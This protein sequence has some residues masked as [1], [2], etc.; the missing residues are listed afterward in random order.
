MHGRSQKKLPI[1]CSEGEIN[2]SVSVIIE[3]V[4]DI[5]PRIEFGSVRTAIKGYLDKTIQC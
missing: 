5:G 1:F 2:G 4:G 3:L